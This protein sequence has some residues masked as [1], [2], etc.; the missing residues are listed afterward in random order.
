LVCRFG[1]AQL[2]RRSR[3]GFYSVSALI[4]SAFINRL[5]STAPTG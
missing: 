2:L 1:V 4:W 5:A 3:I